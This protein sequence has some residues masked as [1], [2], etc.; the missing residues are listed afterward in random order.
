MDDFIMQAD[1]LDLLI[2]APLERGL[3]TRRGHSGPA[4]R[5]VA[6]S[7]G[8]GAEVTARRSIGSGPDLLARLPVGY[9]IW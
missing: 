6:S 2:G 5:D 4:P 1:R 3:G 9:W 7:A 8:R